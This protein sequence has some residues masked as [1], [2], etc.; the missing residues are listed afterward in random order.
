MCARLDERRFRGTEETAATHGL[1]C[2]RRVVYFDT[3]CGIAGFSGN[4]DRSLLN[5]MSDAISH[6]GPDDADASVARGRRTGPRASPAI[7]HR[8]VRRGAQPMWDTT[9]SRCIVFNGEIYNYR[10]LRAELERDDSSSRT[11]P[12]PRSF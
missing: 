6:R 5:R 10:E 4:F 1:V 9:R 12:T 11:T 2:G 7:D 3:M 8:F